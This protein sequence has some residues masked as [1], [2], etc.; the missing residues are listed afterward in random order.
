M[1]TEPH[2]NPTELPKTWTSGRNQIREYIPT[3]SVARSQPWF[4]SSQCPVSHL[5]FTP[6]LQKQSPQLVRMTI[7]D[8][9][10]TCK[11]HDDG[12]STWLVTSDGVSLGPLD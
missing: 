2:R 6:L 4:G 8:T 11:R 7:Y 10:S 12:D 3:G 1:T 9:S 5:P